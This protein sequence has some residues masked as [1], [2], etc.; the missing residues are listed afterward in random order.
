MPNLDGGHYYLTALVP[1]LLQPEA[2]DQETG[3]VAPATRLRETLALMASTGGGPPQL[4]GAVIND[5]RV[6]PFARNLRNHFVRFAV[7]DD[8]NYNGRIA[9][10]GL[11]EAVTGVD[12]AQPQPQDRLS[13]PYLLFA[14]EFD[15][16]TEGAMEPDVYLDG[17]WTT[18]EA[19]LRDIFRHC[20]GF[21]GVRGATEFVRYIK[22]CQI[23]T[24]MPFND[25]WTGSPP[26]KPLSLMALGAAALLAGA[27]V[28]TATY[29]GLRMLWPL[30]WA[31]AVAI[32]IA[33]VVAGV[34]AAA[35]VWWWGGRPF[36]AAPQGDL[37]SVLKALY[38]QRTF[39]D[40]AIQAQGLGPADLHAAFGAYMAEHRPR[41]AE[42]RQP[43][44]IVG[45]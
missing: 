21:S 31:I 10:D 9:S 39:V 20:Y 2:G 27:L 33:I 24:T 36:P 22:A 6:S 23:E 17:L 15:P 37:K 18:M 14:A 1:V 3:A 42:P 12:P 32:G 41:E 45:I 8:P 34:V 19:E 44:G 7:I 5:Q 4:A 25:Y 11:L 40:F 26:F 29:M 28:G 38:L 35:I 16:N 13:R 43:P 30:G